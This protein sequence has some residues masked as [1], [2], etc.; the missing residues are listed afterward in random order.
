MTPTFDVRVSKSAEL[1]SVSSESLTK[2][3]EDAGIKNDS[4]GI[5]LLE[6]HTTMI[7]DIVDILQS[8]CASKAK[9]LQLKAELQCSKVTILLAK[10][11]NLNL[12]R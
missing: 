1:L 4:I 2:T 10:K 6:A 7:E 9:K 12:L 3:L 5:A 11:L 8:D